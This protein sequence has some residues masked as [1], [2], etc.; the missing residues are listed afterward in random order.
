[1]S[2]FKYFSVS[3]RIRVIAGCSARV[4]DPLANRPAGPEFL[5]DRLET[6]Q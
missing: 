2:T 5:A 3:G 4:G 6:T 1:M